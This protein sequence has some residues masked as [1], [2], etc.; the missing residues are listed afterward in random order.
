MRSYKTSFSPILESWE[1]KQWEC[2]L[3]RVTKRSLTCRKALPSLSVGQEVVF[4]INELKELRHLEGELSLSK[5]EN[6]VNVMQAKEAKEANLKNKQKLDN[7]Q[8]RWSTEISHLQDGKDVGKAG[9]ESLQPHTGL[10]NLTIGDYCGLRFSSWIM[11]DLSCY[12]RLVSV[13][14]YS[15][16]NCK[17]LPP[18]GQLCSLKA[19]EIRKMNNVEYYICREQRNCASKI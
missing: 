4:N 11:T 7:L 14:L 3:R 10:K 15:C 5:L 6:V 8:L 1:W 17:I 18:L 12:T 9:L 19:L 13:I 16:G 2:I